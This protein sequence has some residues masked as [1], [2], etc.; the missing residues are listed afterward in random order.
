M[1]IRALIV[2]VPILI[3]VLMIFVN[4]PFENDVF[5]YKWHVGE[6]YQ[7]IKLTK[8][9]GTGGNFSLH[10]D[11]DIIVKEGDFGTTLWFE[12]HII[13]VLYISPSKDYVRYRKSSIRV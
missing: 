5:G 9:S 6:E 3:L 7:G 10:W 11:K 12:G 13:E 1:G 4:N 8:I 2:S